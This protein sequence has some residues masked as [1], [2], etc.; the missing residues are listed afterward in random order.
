LIGVHG[1]MPDGDLLLTTAS[2]F[3]EGIRQE[4]SFRLAPH[5]PQQVKLGFT[6]NKTNQDQVNRA[7]GA[8]GETRRRHATRGAARQNCAIQYR[9]A[10]HI[11]GRVGGTR[12]VRLEQDGPAILPLHDGC[13]GA[14]P[15]V[16]DEGRQS[17]SSR[18][19]SRGACCRSRD[20]RAFEGH[21]PG[22]R[23]RRAGTGRPSGS[24]LIWNNPDIVHE[25][26][27]RA[28]LDKSRRRDLGRVL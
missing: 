13:T 9:Q 24:H 26:S 28:A 5:H 16:D 25:E 17:F 14:N 23:L 22:V 21:A 8:A 12:P 15:T 3:V 20:R 4:C 27:T 6:S 1:D 19:R 11:Q 10:V 18:P 7:S 2:P